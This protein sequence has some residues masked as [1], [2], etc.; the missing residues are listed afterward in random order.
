MPTVDRDGTSLYYETDGE[1][2]TV[3]FV[4]DAGCGAWFWGWQH[5]ALAGP[6]ES[7][8]WNTRGTGRS[9]PPKGDMSMATFVNDLDAVL[10][11]HG[12][13]TVHLV[14]CGLGAMV[15]LAYARKHD[16]VRSLTLVS[17]A[18]T[19]DS[20]DPE[21]FFAS[22]D[23]EDACRETL[24]SVLS[25]AFCED[26]PDVLD[27][28]ASWRAAED[29]DRETWDRQVAALDGFDAA[30]LY[31][32]TVPTLVVS[33]G[34]DGLLAERSARELADGLPRGEL[35]DYPDAG[36]WV[37]VERSRPLNDSITDFVDAAAKAET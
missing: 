14:G 22:P 33:G 16:R 9:D 23:D 37:H 24:S 34:A 15:A 19:G 30:P 28:I 26:H 35:V 2:E 36:H 11:D 18:A 1:G 31:E 13:R 6:Y 21:P 8:V 4:P 17:G 29:A 10:S 5:A 27:G 25:A 20:Y 7:L 12:A 32:V 3:A